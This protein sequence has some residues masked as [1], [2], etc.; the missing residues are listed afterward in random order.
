MRHAP[1]HNV[2]HVVHEVRAL[3]APGRGP[4]LP[5]YLAV[6]LSAV[7]L[8]GVLPSP[9]SAGGVDVLFS[10]DMSLELAMGRFEPPGDVVVVRGNHVAL[11]NWTG[12]G[13]ELGPVSECGVCEGW[14]RFEGLSAGDDVEYKFVVNEGGDPEVPM[15]EVSIANRVVSPSGDEPDEIPAPDGDGYSELVLPT[16]Y[17]DHDVGW[18]P[19]DR[20]IGADLSF[21]P[22]LQSLGAVYSVDGEAVDPVVAFSDHGFELVRLRLWHTPD[23][24]WQGLDATVAHAAEAMAAGHQIM[25]DIHYSDTWADPGHQTKPAAWEGLSFPALVESVYVYTNSVMLRFRDEGVI[26]SYVQ[27]GNEISGGMLWDDGRVGGVWDTPQQWENLATILDAGSSA[28]RDSIPE[29]LR[30]R[31]VIH[32]DNG[33]NNDLCRWFFDNMAAHDVDYDTIGLSFYP[34]WHGTLWDLRDNLRDLALTYGKEIFVVETA[35]PW[36]LEWNDDTGNFVGSADDLH[37]GYPATPAGQVDF[38]RDLL[39]IIEGTPGGL[40]RGPVYWEP[41]YLTVPGGPGNPYEN[42]TLFDFEG[43][44]LPG[45]GFSMP[46]ET[47]LPDAGEEHGA[48]PML[49]PSGPNPFRASTRLD[50]AVPRGGA[51]V[52]VAVYDVSG[53][54]VAT[55][56]DG[57][58][59][60]GTHS[61][62]WSGRADRGRCTSTGVY[63]CRA[64]VGARVE[65]AKLVL[66]R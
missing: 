60:G 2:Q 23:D 19:S 5:V 59:S 57:F 38:L 37:P 61:L 22:M 46:W 32:L 18:R 66:L 29:E 54:R 41:C 26:P 16:T 62:F 31:I 51:A 10:V 47:G 64:E 40:G 7:A 63:F 35:Y 48:L 24:P 53:R 8:M 27:I 6:A 17:F 28:V 9:A 3:A 55:L 30:P 34:W 15:W 13:V 44:A 21:V 52:D 4:L 1:L 20:L 58:L 39:S 36:T 49:S 42:L 33:G 45:L 11:G 50:L 65:T 56:A 12:A 43:V 25:L 14:V